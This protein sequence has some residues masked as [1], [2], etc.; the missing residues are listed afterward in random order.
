MII[1]DPIYRYPYPSNFEYEYQNKPKIMQ[2]QELERKNLIVFDKDGTLTT[3]KSGHRFVQ[4]PEDQILLPNV[5]NHLKD[6]RNKG[7]IFAVASNQYGVGAGFKTL[8]SAIQEM[9]FLI[10]MLEAEEINIRRFLICPDI[11]GKDCLLVNSG[12]Y[13]SLMNDAY[14]ILV[15]ERKPEKIDL[16][17]LKLQG[18]FRKPNP[19]M[20]K[21]I[22]ILDQNQYIYT[23]K[24]MVGDMRSDRQA[25]DN[26]EFDQYLDAV[27]WREGRRQVRG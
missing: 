27:D 15:D 18:K 12:G 8:D 16:E 1:L 11:Q 5:L 21:A 6:L 10:K 22:P 2:N 17:L 25:A 20:L 14:D 13:I 9:M 23:K 19:G 7:Y 24:I 4:H 26:A 3:S